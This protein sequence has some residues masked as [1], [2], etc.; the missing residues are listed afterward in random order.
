MA[1]SHRAP[2]YMKILIVRVK[3]SGPNV[4]SSSGRALARYERACV[5]WQDDVRRAGS[6]R[7][8]FAAPDIAWRPCGLWKWANDSSTEQWF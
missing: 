5:D 6:A 3:T 4:C 1:D 2:P 7:P 8:P